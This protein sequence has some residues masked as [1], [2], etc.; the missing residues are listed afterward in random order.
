MVSVFK[1]E[2]GRFFRFALQQTATHMLKFWQD[3]WESQCTLQSLLAIDPHI[4]IGN[5][6]NNNNNR[7]K[8]I[9][10]QYDGIILV[11]L[12]VTGTITI[13]KSNRHN[14]EYALQCNGR[15]ERN[16]ENNRITVAI[17]EAVT[18]TATT[19]TAIRTTQTRTRKSNC[20]PKVYYSEIGLNVQLTGSSHIYYAVI[21]FHVFLRV[22]ALL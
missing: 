7:T 17:A 19:A 2:L 12:P 10:A 16:E 22:N 5:K 1:V 21:K 13:W 14:N 6:N 4:G 15:E 3:T 8:T 20:R 11:L 9:Q 18:T